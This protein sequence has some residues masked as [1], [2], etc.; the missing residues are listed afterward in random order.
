[1]Y[2]NR[3]TYRPHPLPT[4]PLPLL[5]HKEMKKNLLSE[6]AVYL[7]AYI[8]MYLFIGLISSY[9]MVLYYIMHTYVDSRTGLGREVRGF[10]FPSQIV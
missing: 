3:E 1:M 9:C 2:L 7:H 10:F 8:R 4:P 6:P 5:S